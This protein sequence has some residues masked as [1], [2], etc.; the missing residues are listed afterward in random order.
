MLRFVI[1]GHF[2]LSDSMAESI[3]P[4]KYA[5]HDRNQQDAQLIT[6]CFT[7]LKLTVVP[8]AESETHA[9][10]ASMQDNSNVTAAQ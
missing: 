2:S 4:D 10:A 3:Q 1:A 8:S 5:N 6:V 9:S 7:V